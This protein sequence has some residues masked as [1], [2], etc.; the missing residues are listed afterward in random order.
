MCL[1]PTAFQYGEP[2]PSCT[3][4]IGVLNEF[5]EQRPPVS[6]IPVNVGQQDL[7]CLYLIERTSNNPGL[8]PDIDG[9]VYV[10]TFVHEIICSGLG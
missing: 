6:G 8:A 4:V 1:G 9:W 7:D 5:P 10:G 3:S 2:E